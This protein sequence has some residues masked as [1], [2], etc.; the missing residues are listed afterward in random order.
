MWKKNDF[1]SFVWPLSRIL[2]NSIK[3]SVCISRDYSV[4]Y[5]FSS[6]FLFTI[7]IR[8]TFFRKC[9]SLFKN[10]MGLFLFVLNSSGACMQ[11]NIRDK[12]DN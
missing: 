4:D 12:N 7:R 8:L 10:I 9:Y 2:F 3:Y 5:W 6:L 1:Y 11:K